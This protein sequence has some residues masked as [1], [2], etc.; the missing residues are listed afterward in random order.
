[1]PTLHRLALLSPLLLVVSCKSATQ[2]GPSLHQMSRDL[3]QSRPV[4]SDADIAALEGIQPQ[5]EFPFHLAIAPPVVDGRNL[6][7]WS[8]E[9]IAILDGFAEDLRAAGV[10]SRVSILPNLLVSAHAEDA[11]LVSVR[12]AAARSQADAVL[13]VNSLSDSQHALNLLSVLDLTLV[14]AWIFPGHEVAARAVLEGL[15]VDTRNEYLYLAGQA[16]IESDGKHVAL[17]YAGEREEDLREEVRLQALERLGRTL[18]GRAG[19]MLSEVERERV[20]AGAT[21]RLARP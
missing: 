21:T 15:L 7:T 18:L 17:A 11:F 1:M 6:G 12:K 16:E 4:F 19:L 13:L 10:V 14:G 2:M 9:E 20:D 5:L 8:E 3:S